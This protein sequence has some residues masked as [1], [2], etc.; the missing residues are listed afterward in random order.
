MPQKS[1]DCIS[2]WIPAT[3]ASVTPS[4][5]TAASKARADVIEH[6]ELTSLR[7]AMIKSVRMDRMV[8]AV[9]FQILHVDI[10]LF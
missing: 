2:L 4:T 1:I 5:A 7:R 10:G 3:A 9:A 6:S 8:P